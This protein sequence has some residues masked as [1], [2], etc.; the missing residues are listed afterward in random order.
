MDPLTSSTGFYPLFAKVYGQL[1]GPASEFRFIPGVTPLS[2]FREVVIG[3]LLYFVVIFGGQ[4]L[5]TNRPPMRLSLLS[6]AHNLILT[7]VSGALLILI[8]EQI[9]PKVYEHGLFYGL[10]SDDAWTQPL[11][12]LYYLNYLV[13][14]WEFLD[15]V[16]LVLK[17]KKLGKKMKCRAL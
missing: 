2:T 14:Y 17:K 5:M 12:Q 7:L 15:T 3:F 6:Q 8:A 9:L 10:C 4:Y 16:F 13:K 1:I 11:E